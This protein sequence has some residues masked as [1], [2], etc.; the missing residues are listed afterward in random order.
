MANRF[1]TQPQMKL[2]LERWEYDFICHAFAAFDVVPI[3]IG[4]VNQR[5]KG[6]VQAQPRGRFF[7]D[8]NGKLV[9]FSVEISI[10]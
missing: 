8:R 1:Q 5:Q 7:I 2:A 3:G 9:G 10:A 4:H 6:L